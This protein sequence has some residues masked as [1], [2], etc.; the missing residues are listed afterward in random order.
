VAAWAAL[1]LVTTLP[2]VEQVVAPRPAAGGADPGSDA[3]TLADAPA[4]LRDRGRAVTGADLEAIALGN[5][6]ELAQARYIQS[7]RAAR[8][9]VVATGQDPRPGKALREVLRARL[10]SVTLPR[11]AAKG[12]LAVDPPVLRPLALTAAL[13]VESLDVG[14]TVDAAARS[15][16]EQLL[17]PATGGVEGS[18]WPLGAMPAEAD[19]MAVLVGIDGLVGVTSLVLSDVDAAGVLHAPPRVLAADELAVL[20][21][22][23]LV[24]SLTPVTP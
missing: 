10:A 17:D 7:G 11:L 4:A 15:A 9:V 8:L 13:T 2:G 24:L 3:A 6:S 20:A 12:G 16:L 5:T 14:G 21:P 19:V 18:G 22:D 23:R 1:N